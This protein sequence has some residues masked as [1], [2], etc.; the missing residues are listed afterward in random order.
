MSKVTGKDCIA[1]FEAN[2][3]YF[4]SKF[5]VAVVKRYIL[6]SDYTPA[7]ILHKIEA[8]VER[9]RAER[10]VKA[11]EQAVQE[12]AAKFNEDLEAKQELVNEINNK[13]EAAQDLI[14]T[15]VEAEDVDPVEVQNNKVVE[16]IIKNVDLVNKS[17]FIKFARGS[18]SK[19]KQI[20]PY[21][22]NMLNQFKPISELNVK[23]YYKVDG[24][25][26]PTPTTF[27]LDNNIGMQ[28]MNML[29]DGKTYELIEN[30]FD[31]NGQQQEIQIIW[32]ETNIDNPHALTIDMITGIEIVHKN[33]L[34]RKG[35][36]NCVS[37]YSDNG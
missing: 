11:Q 12:E 32:S 3:E 6:N 27:C 4:P 29:L 18:K 14:E 17:L 28:K 5:T 37:I 24:K 35:D 2:R 13:A 33:N 15:E 25:P 8:K 36:D 21:I 9:I 30:I 19:F 1:Y 10:L 26:C 16:N 22:I 31:P 23:V 20:K 7:E 34:F